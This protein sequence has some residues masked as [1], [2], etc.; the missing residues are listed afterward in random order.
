LVYLFLPQNH[1]YSIHDEESS[2]F[3]YQYDIDE[4]FDAFEQC[5][6]PFEQKTLEC[7][8]KAGNDEESSLYKICGKNDYACLV[9]GCVGS[10]FDA[11]RRIESEND[12]DMGCAELILFEDFSP[13]HSDSWGGLQPVQNSSFGSPF[14]QLIKGE[15]NATKTIAVPSDA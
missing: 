14:L 9:D 13:S 6:S 4:S 3:V 7:V 8:E 15:S 11:Q 1:C 10:K 12:A 5:T 2:L